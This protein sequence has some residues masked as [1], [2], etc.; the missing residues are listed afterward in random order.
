VSEV[1]LDKIKNFICFTTVIYKH[2]FK[3][4]WP[5]P[6]T[7]ACLCRDVFFL[8]VC[9]QIV[10]QKIKVHDGLL[11][12]GHADICILTGRSYSLLSEQNISPSRIGLSV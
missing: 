5:K 12:V 4:C 10:T 11:R 6:V 1:I 9:I 7:S 8:V 2:Y 3:F